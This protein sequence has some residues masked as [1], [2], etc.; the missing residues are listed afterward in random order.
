MRILLTGGSGDLGQVLSKELDIRGDIPVRLDVRVPMNNRGVSILGS[1]LDRPLLKRSMEGMDCIVHIA[2]WHGIHDVTKVKDVYQ[3]W[4]LNVTGTFYVFEAA[5]EAGVQR[6]VHISSESVSDWSGIYGHTKVLGEEI[7]RTYAKRHGL[8]VLILRPRAFIPYWNREVYQSF[9]D[10]AKWFWPGAVHIDDVSQA[11]LQAIDLLAHQ[12]PSFPLAL[13]VDGAY[14]YTNEDLLK[15]DKGGPGTTFRK[16]YPEYL[17]V[18]ISFGLNPAQ[19]PVKLDI[20]ETQRWLGYE[21]HY[22]LK[23]LLMELDRFGEKG[24][25]FPVF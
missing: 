5:V 10:W 24:P 22:S 25:P 19:K 15:W 16:Y 17:D 11:V 1:I 9:V 2:A 7:A 6:I 21:P 8:K 18:A 14:E 3:F 13:P 23:N 20:T 12:A 4:D